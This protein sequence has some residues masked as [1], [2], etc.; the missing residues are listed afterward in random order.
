M[1]LKAKLLWAFIL[2]GLVIIWRV[3]MDDPTDVDAEIT[4]QQD[5]RKQIKKDTEAKIEKLR[6]A[7]SDD[8][9]IDNLNDASN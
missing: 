6:K 2:G 7:D 1:K 5:K 4:K 8:D 3:V 9:V